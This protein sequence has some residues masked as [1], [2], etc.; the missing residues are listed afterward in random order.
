MRQNTDP[1]NLASE[2]SS[3]HHIITDST[4]ENDV[5]QIIIMVLGNSMKG[6]HLVLNLIKHRH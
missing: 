2:Q 4:R 6:G 3:S 1:E 5:L